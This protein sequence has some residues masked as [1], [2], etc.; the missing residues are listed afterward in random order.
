MIVVIQQR[1][2]NNC[3]VLLQCLLANQ[4]S[5]ALIHQNNSGWSERLSTYQTN[6]QAAWK[7]R[8]KLYLKLVFQQIHNNENEHIKEVELIHILRGIF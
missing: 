1:A 8:G 3:T 6:L 4:K 2:I 7:E 5:K